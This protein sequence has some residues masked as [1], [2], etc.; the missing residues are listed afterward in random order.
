MDKASDIPVFK[1]GK[2]SPEEDKALKD[3][4]EFYEEKNWKAIAKELGQ[5][6]PLQCFNRWSLILKLNLIKGPWQ[7]HEDKTLREW[8]KE[9]GPHGWPKCSRQI[10]GRNS[11]QC[12][13]RYLKMLNSDLFRSKWTPEEDSILF[14]MHKKYGS[15]WSLIAKSLPNRTVLSIKSHFYEIK[16]KLQK[17]FPEL[18][19]N[20]KF[21]ID[22]IVPYVRYSNTHKPEENALSEAKYQGTEWFRDEK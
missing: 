5:R 15:K 14:I 10:P 17:K 21:K 1:Q 19:V 4:V 6:S 13:R 8:V 16:K 20:G 18:I 9:N 2:W 7:P 12:R 3:A 11:K 22:S